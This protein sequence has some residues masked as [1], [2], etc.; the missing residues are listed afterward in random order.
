MSA[1]S[2]KVVVEIAGQHVFALHFIQGC[3]PQL[4]GRPFFAEHDPGAVWLSHPRPAFADR[5]PFDPAFE[6]APL[7]LLG[8][9]TDECS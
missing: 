4:V 8:A 9:L 2:G 1:T 7:A 3:D 5:F 6:Q